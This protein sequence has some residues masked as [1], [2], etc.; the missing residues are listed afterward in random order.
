MSP[1]PWPW[2]PPAA[3]VLLGDV[4]DE[5]LGGQDHRRDRGGVLEGGAGHLGGV[6]DALLEHVAVLVAEGVVAW[7]ILRS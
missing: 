4:G 1:P 6:H 3:A 7:P 5:R 2:P